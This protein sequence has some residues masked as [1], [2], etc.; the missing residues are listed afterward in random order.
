MEDLKTMSTRKTIQERTIDYFAKYPS[1]IKKTL[2]RTEENIN[3]G[4]LSI[5]RGERISFLDKSGSD[6][7]F[8]GEK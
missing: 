1:A 5:M 7:G 6:H 8:T 3:A 4:A 2:K